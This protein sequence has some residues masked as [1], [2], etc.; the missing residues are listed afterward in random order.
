MW[1]TKQGRRRGRRRKKKQGNLLESQSNDQSNGKQ[2]SNRSISI[3]FIYLFT[4]PLNG[5]SPAL[6]ANVSE[7]WASTHKSLGFQL[8]DVK[9]TQYHRHETHD[10][11]SFFRFY[12]PQRNLSAILYFELFKEHSFI[13]LLFVHLW[14][15]K[16]FRNLF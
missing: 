8:F 3:Y 14:R 4:W 9:L 13:Y 5:I 15:Q 12:W 7:E 16:D 10:V 2:K 11:C 1:I 6:F